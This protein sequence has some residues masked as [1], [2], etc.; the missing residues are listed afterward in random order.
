V[1]TFF[2]QV[3]PIGQKRLVNFKHIQNRPGYGNVRGTAG[4]HYVMKQRKQ[5][6]NSRLKYG[7]SYAINFARLVMSGIIEKLPHAIGFFGT[8]LDEIFQN[9]HALFFYSFQTCNFS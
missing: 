2:D 1:P 4:K 8:E 3:D 7:V 6:K 9:Y 5:G